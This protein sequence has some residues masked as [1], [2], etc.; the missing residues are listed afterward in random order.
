MGWIGCMVCAAFGHCAPSGEPPII[1]AA[2]WHT[3]GKISPEG[4]DARVHGLRKATAAAY[5]LGCS[6]GLPGQ[7]SSAGA[8]ES[9]G[10]AIKKSTSKGFK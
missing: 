5:R 10:A 6:L 4:L 1:G 9:R 8:L 2:A 7:G 3:T